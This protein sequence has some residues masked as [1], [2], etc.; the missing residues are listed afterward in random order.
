MRLFAMGIPAA[1]ASAFMPVPITSPTASSGGLVRVYSTIGR[2]IPVD[3]PVALPAL[4]AAP[5][6]PTQPSQVAPNSITPDHYWPGAENMHAPVPTRI[7]NEIPLPTI[8]PIRVPRAVQT[9]PGSTSF[10]RVIAWPA[11]SLPWAQ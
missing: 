6:V 5:S 7:R 3:G 11:P 8:N 2:S 9:R 1:G 10:R 4:S